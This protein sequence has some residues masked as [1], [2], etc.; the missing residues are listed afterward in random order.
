MRVRLGLHTGE[1]TLTASGYVGLDVHRAARICAAGHGGQT[2]LSQT[3][4]TLVE[5]DLPA[6]VRLQHLGAHRL[7]D[8]QRPEGLYQLVIPD[9]PADFP[10]L[11]SLDRRAHN[12]PVQPT[13]LIGR[14]Q[15]GA[16]VCGLLRRADVRLL[17]LTGPGGTGKTRLGL[18][19]AADLLEDFDSGV[20]F[21]PLAAIRDSALVAS[22]I[23]RT[24]DIQE[25]AGQVLLDS[26]QESLQDKR[27]LLVLDNFEQVLDAAPDVVHTPS[28]SVPG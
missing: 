7:K 1:P 19:V 6:G 23:A 3:T 14:E 8:L 12:L 20:F 17:T 11:Q 15:V 4:H 18:Q 22:S 9:L 10:P 13:P 25:K 24:L 5:Y 26:L 21:V 28:R 16:A 2:L 27:L